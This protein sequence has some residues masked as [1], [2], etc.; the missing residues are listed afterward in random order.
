MGE[1]ERDGVRDGVLSLAAEAMVVCDV[2][3]KQDVVRST[4]DAGSMFHMR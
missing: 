2:V 1:D 3:S 4:L